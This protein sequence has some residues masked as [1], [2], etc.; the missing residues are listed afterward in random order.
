M[1][2]LGIET[3]CDETSAAVVEDGSEIL[4]QVI[5]SQID[6]H[7][8]TGGVVPEVASRHHVQQ[9]NA[10]IGEAVSKA[11]LDLGDL[12]AVAV[13]NRPGLLGAL[14]V[15]VSAAK[16]LSYS[17]KIP[18]IGVH[19][20]EGHIHANFLGNAK[21]DFP[22]V[23][24]VASGGHSELI[25]MHDHGDY[26]SLGRTLD[27]AAGEAFDKSARLIGLP[28]PGGVQIDKLARNG[29]PKAISLP[30]ANLGRNSLDFSFS[31]LKTAV[32][33]ATSAHFQ[34]HSIEDW[35]ASIQDAI[36]EPLVEKT[37]RAARQNCAAAVM[38]CGGVSANSRLQIS[39]REVCEAAGIPCVIP[40]PILCTDNGAMIACAGW[41]HLK[42]GERSDLSL[43]TIAHERLA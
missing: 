28:Y 12:D 23:C 30:R 11:G 25:L 34:E 5:A 14:L 9:I 32:L 33:N 16:A 4:S 22:A 8:L 41:H 37:I 29:N 24:L 6:I 2:V 27:D 39:L 17:L 20:I 38:A 13:T 40:P 42:K 26:L 18:L 43:D 7:A 10:V 19:H 21:I 35:A 15:G 1:K 36:I 31:G 3:S